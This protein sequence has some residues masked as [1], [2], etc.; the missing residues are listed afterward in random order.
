MRQYACGHADVGER[1]RHCGFRR[2]R[3][4][5][6][7]TFALAPEDITIETK[8]CAFCREG[9]TS[10]GFPDQDS[11]HLNAVSPPMLGFQGCG[12]SLVEQNSKS[13]ALLIGECDVPYEGPTLFYKD[14]TTRKKAWINAQ[15]S[16]KEALYPRKLLGI[17]CPHCQKRKIR[18]DLAEPK[19]GNCSRLGKDCWLPITGPHNL[20]DGSSKPTK[21]VQEA[22]APRKRLA[23]ACLACREKNI[24][25]DPAEP[26][27]IQCAKFGRDCRLPTLRPR[28]LGDESLK[29]TEEVEKSR[30]RAMTCG[31]CQLPKM[32][33]DGA[34]PKCGNCT[35][36]GQYCW[37]VPTGLRI[38][39][40]RA[41]CIPCREKET[42]CDPAEPKCIQCTK[43]GR[44]CRLPTPGPRNLGDDPP[45]L[46]EEV[47]KSE[48]AR[49]LEFKL[50]S[51]DEEP[52]EL[53]EQRRKREA[54]SSSP[55]LESHYFVSETMK[56]NIQIKY[57]Y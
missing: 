36:L 2:M 31:H 5:E 23:I 50:S 38:S 10:L 44:D 3:N 42:K 26:K 21:E 1:L 56:L 32:L 20:G 29:L 57:S 6:C 9:D 14:G 51:D 19:C 16:V 39:N 41:A 8:Q 45:K 4:R 48:P 46:T 49:S 35:K 17:A 12:R 11:A 27:C 53:I 28:N 37:V 24:K 40:A 52:I 25:C 47:R 55:E 13:L 34:E 15:W 7:N 18:C 43:F 33:C 54:A 30:R 22:L